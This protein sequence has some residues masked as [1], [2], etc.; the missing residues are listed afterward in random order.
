[1]HN[2]CRTRFLKHTFWNHIVVNTVRIDWQFRCSEFKVPKWRH[3]QELGFKSKDVFNH[4]SPLKILAQASVKSNQHQPLCNSSCAPA[5]A[6][7]KNPFSLLCRQ[8]LHHSLAA[9][10][11]LQLLLSVIKAG[12]SYLGHSPFIQHEQPAKMAERFTGRKQLNDKNVKCYA[13]SCVQLTRIQ[14][15]TLFQ[16]KPFIR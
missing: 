13:A 3:I 11:H 2:K 10:T 5:S 1:M 4:Q 15:Y 8:G 9:G 12:V 16:S 6:W 7:E 14:I